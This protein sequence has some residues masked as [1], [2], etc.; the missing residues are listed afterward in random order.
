MYMSEK[1]ERTCSNCLYWSAER[2]AFRGMCMVL[3]P[4]VVKDPTQSKL[5][6]ASPYTG[7]DRK[8]C[9]LWHSDGSDHR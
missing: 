1:P 3:P 2:G 7:K 6:A 8:A 9:M 4:T 5:I